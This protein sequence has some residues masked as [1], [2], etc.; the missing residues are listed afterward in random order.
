MEYAALNLGELL[1]LSQL[2]HLSGAESFH[3]MLTD[4][5]MAL[6]FTFLFI[7]ICFL[8]IC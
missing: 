4:Q 1:G 3:N 5:P 2:S 6:L 7:V 8:I